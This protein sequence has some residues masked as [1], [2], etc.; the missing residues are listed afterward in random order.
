GYAND[1][2]GLSLVHFKREDW[3]KAYAEMKSASAIYMA[4]DQR[5]AGSVATRAI[6]QPPGQS[7]RHATIFLAQAFTAYYL[8]EKDPAAADALR[9]EAFQMAQRAQS[10]QAAAALGQMAARFSSGTDALAALVRQRQD[11]AVE[12]Q[13]LDNRLTTALS[14][15]PGQQDQEK[16]QAL[17]QRLAGIATRLDSFD[18]RFS[19]QLPEYAA[20]TNPQPLGIADVQQLLGPQEAL[21][22]IASQPHESLIWVIGKDEV[23]WILV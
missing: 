8:A 17:R 2:A 5:V 22:L 21:L 1:V 11:L 16:E 18:A 9:D 19:K 10:S 13:V 23:Q 15:P 14:A 20:L 4:F 7:I 12:W 6:A 3:A